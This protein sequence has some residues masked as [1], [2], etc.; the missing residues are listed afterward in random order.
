[1]KKTQK[2]GLTH[3]QINEILMG[4]CSNQLT[5]AKK[6][7]EKYLRR[8]KKCDN[9]VKFFNDGMANAQIQN[10]EKSKENESESKKETQENK[11][12]NKQ[13]KL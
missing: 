3:N 10:Q 5:E 4:Y 2:Q 8:I 9:L 12:E 13:Q 6:E 7:P 11:E 1:M